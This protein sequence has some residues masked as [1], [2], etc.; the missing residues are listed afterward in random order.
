MH[1][2]KIL[3]AAFILLGLGSQLSG[4]A[5]AQ[6]YEVKFS[7]VE[8]SSI[9][10]GG[11]LI[12]QTEG[13]SE[14]DRAV[15]FTAVEP[16]MLT[17]EEALSTPIQT[18]STVQPNALVGEGTLDDSDEQLKLDN[19]VRLDHFR[20]N[21]EAGEQI[22]ITGESSDFDIVVGLFLVEEEQLKE[23]AINDNSSETTTNAK[24]E[25][26]L[27]S[28]GTYAVIVGPA[29]ADGQGDYVITLDGTGEG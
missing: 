22:I 5:L 11:E 10:S 23:I 7:D 27:D 8:L 19:G 4:S 25:T 6:F 26:T 3:P 1:F 29:L 12:E 17:V 9:D 15:P 2:S 18:A 28:T 14:A 13:K 16:A 20:F 21:G 24:I